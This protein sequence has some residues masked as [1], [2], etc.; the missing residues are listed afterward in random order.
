MASYGTP[1]G[2]G[3]ETPTP[4]GAELPELSGE[5]LQQLR[6]DQLASLLAAFA[7][8]SASTNGGADGGSGPRVKWALENFDKPAPAP[9]DFH[10]WRRSVQEWL[11]AH[12]HMDDV[13]HL[14]HIRGALRGEAAKE[15]RR[16]ELQFGPEEP[17]TSE[18]LLSSLSEFYI[19]FGTSEQ[20]RQDMRQWRA[21]P[22][23][24]VASLNQFMD[25]TT[26]AGVNPSESN[27]WE[28]YLLQGLPYDLQRRVRDDKASSIRYYY[29]RAWRAVQEVQALQKQ[30]KLPRAEA[31][32][33][34]EDF[35]QP[36]KSP[37]LGQTT[38]GKSRASSHSSGSSGGASLSSG[39]RSPWC[40]YHQEFGHPTKQCRALEQK[41]RQE[42]VK[43]TDILAS[44]GK[45][46]PTGDGHLGA[47]GSG[48]FRSPSGTK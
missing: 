44:R 12:P 30:S 17:L 35:V 5:Q 20:A 39:Q 9:L 41:A 36:A 21:K 2:G 22:G 11:S 48:N 31:T 25:L 7:K 42:G 47:K 3:A 13:T 45:A 46:R 34:L 29:N 19:P 33:N 37:T 8:G 23:A 16:L 40:S 27:G 38:D 43:P 15:L 24:V 28:D 18:R 14:H 10:I 4:E 32:L 1:G 26:L 6:K